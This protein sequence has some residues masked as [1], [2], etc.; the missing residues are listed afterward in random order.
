MTVETLANIKKVDLR[1]AWPNESS[2]FTPWLAGNLSAL[3]AALGLEL[4]L[5]QRE[6]DVGGYS[7]DILAY[8][9]SRDRPVV[10]ENQLETTDHD[11][12]GKLLTYAAGFDA[13]VVVWLTREFRDEHRQALDWL[14]QRTG[15]DTLFFGVVVELWRIDES[16][17]APHFNLV[18]APNDW[19]KESVGRAAERNTGVLSERGERYHAF[20]QALIDTLREKHQFTAAKRAPGG[21]NW[22]AFASGDRRFKY[23]ANFTAQGQARIEV[24]IDSGDGHENVVFFDGIEKQ[25]KKIEDELEC[26]L[27]WDRLEG[28]RACRIATVRS[29]T[30]NDS[31]D[32]DGIRAWMVKN[33]LEFK[34]V[35]GSI[36]ERPDTEQLAPRTIDLRGS[37]TNEKLGET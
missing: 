20:F 13:N 7:L 36:V 4:E 19:R 32:L 10:I 6:A 26:D 18:A 33:L 34:R 30:I 35:F 12:L 17:P 27:D 16:R 28:Y 21:Q 14:N 22:Y 3:S 15:E 1:K 8:D 25:K 2:D 9:L 29:G 37:V 23:G 24:Y 5:R 11:H 31:D